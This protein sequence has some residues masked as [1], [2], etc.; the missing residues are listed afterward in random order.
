M[1]KPS[2]SARAGARSNKRDA[3]ITQLNS[4]M[5]TLASTNRAVRVGEQAPMAR[6]T[7]ISRRRLST[8]NT[9]GAHQAGVA[10]RGD[11]RGQAEEQ[12]HDRRTLVVSEVAL[13]GLDRG[14]EGL[15][16]GTRGGQVR[17]DP[18]AGRPGLVAHEHNGGP[19]RYG[20]PPGLSSWVCTSGALFRADSIA[21]LRA[22]DCSPGRESKARHSLSVAIVALTEVTKRIITMNMTPLKTSTA[23]VN[24]GRCL[25][26][27]VLLTAAA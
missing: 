21:P 7:P 4:P 2:C 9:R 17:F 6:N 11:Q 24:A 5:I 13:L 18:V 8:P 14:R 1:V 23:T 15:A 20:R 26:R 16:R 27:K 19:V 3:A 22:P 12:A 25:C 10:H